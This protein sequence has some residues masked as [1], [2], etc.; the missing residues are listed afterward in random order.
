MKLKPIYLALATTLPL[1]LGGC[2]DSGNSSDTTTTPDSSSSLTGKVMDGYL[3]NAKVCL[4]LNKN[5]A[6]DTNE[7][8]AITAADGSYTMPGV[9]AEQITN[10]PVVS[11]AVGGQTTDTDLDGGVIP[12]SYSLSS[13]AGNGAV[14]SPL[15]TLVHKTMDSSG[16]PLEQAKQDV[17]VK[18]LGIA[19]AEDLD[20]MDDFIAVKNADPTSN[21]AQAAKK[22]HVV[23]QTVT[24]V[25]AANKDKLEKEVSNLTDDDKAALNSFV[26]ESLLNKVQDIAAEAD[27]D[28]TLEDIESKVTTIANEVV[29]NDINVTAVIAEQKEKDELRRATG[30]LTASEF[31]ALFNSGGVLYDVWSDLEHELVYSLDAVYF[32]D[33]VKKTYFIECKFDTSFESCF[34]VQASDFDSIADKPE[35]ES[36]SIQNGKIYLESS[37]GNFVINAIKAL[38]ISGKTVTAKSLNTDYS[39]AD[40]H[41]NLEITFSQGAKRYELLITE[42]GKGLGSPSQFSYANLCSGDDKCHIYGGVETN[43]EEVVTSLPTEETP[44]LDEFMGIKYWFSADKKT[45]LYCETGNCE[46]TTETTPSLYQYDATNKFLTHLSIY[47]LIEEGKYEYEIYIEDKDKLYQNGDWLI[48]DMTFTLQVYNETAAKDIYDV[49]EPQL[50]K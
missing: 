5:S 14:V 16:L 45:L 41:E 3:G 22:A 17:A 13:P 38:D 7:P 27:P 18:I 10:Y 20:V 8:S 30:E 32:N 23:A 43:L 37:E 49:I 47:S 40:E 46:A 31:I 24:R 25:M 50:T 12:K 28:A 2:F 42:E 29:A 4:D 6:C 11:E 19:A 44:F 9:T 48:N 35:F 15:T 1:A 33:S 34:P 26:T 36:Y 21:A 39:F